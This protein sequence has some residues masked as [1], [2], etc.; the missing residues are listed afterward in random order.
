[1]CSCL[2]LGWVISATRDQHWIT[3]PVA[4]FMRQILFFRLK[5][6]PGINSFHHLSSAC[7]FRDFCATAESQVQC[8]L[9]IPFFFLYH[10]FSFSLQLLSVSYLSC[11]SLHLSSKFFSMALHFYA[12]CSFTNI[13]HTALERPVSSSS[14]TTICS[15]PFSLSDAFL[16]HGHFLTH[17]ALLHPDCASR[18]QMHFPCS[19][20][21]FLVIFP[22]CS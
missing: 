3:P 7:E 22:D 6:A 18:I 5:K 8:F 4:P 10:S 17:S 21:S 14:I 2:W 9:L 15:L 1:M 20:L 13:F 16:L 11:H 12:S 19:I